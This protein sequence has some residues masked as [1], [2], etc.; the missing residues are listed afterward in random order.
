MC[1]NIFRIEVVRQK[2]R[3][4]VISLFNIVITNI[5]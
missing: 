5:V 4:C 2:E 1:N 3:G